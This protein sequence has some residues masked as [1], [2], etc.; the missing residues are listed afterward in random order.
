MLK[1]TKI[2][3]KSFLAPIINLQNKLISK[4]VI[5]I[6]QTQKIFHYSPM[7]LYNY[8][9]SI[10]IK[11]KPDLQNH[12]LLCDTPQSENPE[13]GNQDPVDMPDDESDDEDKNE[14][15]SLDEK[16]DEGI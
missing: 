13:N 14:I 1:P 7:K 9:F 8:R 16:V 11:L 15:I 10:N 6:S 2:L 4:N 5:N 12:I 3:N